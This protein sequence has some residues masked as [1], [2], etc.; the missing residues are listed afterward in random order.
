VA[1]PPTSVGPDYFEVF[2]LLRRLEI[3]A[4]KAKLAEYQQ[5]FSSH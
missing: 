3:D 2:G 1:R 5:I 4:V